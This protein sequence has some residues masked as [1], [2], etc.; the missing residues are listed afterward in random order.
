MSDHSDRSPSGAHRWINCPGSVVLEHGIP[1]TGSG[2]ADEGTAAHSV[3]AEILEGGLTHKQAEMLI[4]EEV[5]V[6]GVAWE[7]TREMLD[8]CWAYA[9]KVRELAEGNE[10][11]VEQRVDFS[12]YLHHPDSFGTSDAII[13]GSDNITV[14]DFKYGQGVRVDAEGNEQMMLYALGA[15]AEFGLLA[16][17]RTV[18]MVIIQPRIDHISTWANVPVQ[19]L[20]NFAD[21]AKVA[22]QVIDTLPLVQSNDPI[23]LAHLHPGGKTC[24]WCMARRRHTCPALHKE[25]DDTVVLDFAQF[26]EALPVDRLIND[27]SKVGL[28][29]DWCKAVRAEMERRMLV[30]GEE[31]PGYKIVEG[32]RGNRG[33]IDEDKAEAL[34][35]CFRFRKDDMYALKLI[36]PTQAEKLVAKK[37]PRRWEKLCE[38]VT[39]SDGKPSVA[40][41]TDKRPALASTAQEFAALAVSL[42]LEDQS[43][44]A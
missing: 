1:D 15:L 44:I 9:L 31:M 2:Y 10:L 8:H 20:L 16:D 21:R 14:V 11:L 30:L 24:Q 32:K 26:A 33:W 4:G 40:P 12:S 34:F 38:L 22:S 42:Q 7:I 27:F 39:R 37:Y 35:K 23:V 25:V 5:I 29:E 36:S 18:T 3:C 43:D 19:T 41:V 28:V 13:L 17:Y 6:A